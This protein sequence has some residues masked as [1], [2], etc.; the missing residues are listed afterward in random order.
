MVTSKTEHLKI[1][2]FVKP[3]TKEFLF[4]Q[5]LRL[6]GTPNVSGAKRR[7]G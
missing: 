6:L 1:L 7:A 3:S 5:Q 4:S 2:G